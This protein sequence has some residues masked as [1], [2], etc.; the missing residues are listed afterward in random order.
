M[1]PA[2]SVLV[3]ARADDEVVLGLAWEAVLQVQKQRGS[4]GRKHLRFDVMERI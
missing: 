3:L 4:G 1:S 2:D